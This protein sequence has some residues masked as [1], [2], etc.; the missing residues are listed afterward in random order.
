MQ[1][2]SVH[3]AICDG[4]RAD[5]TTLKSHIPEEGNEALVKCFLL[6]ILDFLGSEEGRQEFKQWKKELSENG[7]K[8]AVRVLTRTATAIKNEYFYTKTKY[9]E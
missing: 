8:M 5:I 6:D 1:N 9:I 3:N 7:Q 2:D 4:K